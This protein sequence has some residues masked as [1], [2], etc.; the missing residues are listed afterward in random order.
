MS[1]QTT[2]APVRTATTVEA[3]IDHAFRVFTEGF[4]TWWPAS[5]HTGDDGFVEA[6]LEPREGGRWYERRRDGA[7]G[8]WGSVLAWEPPHRLLLAWQLDADFQY[9]PDPARATEVEVRFT[10]EGPDRTRVEL[11]HRLL[12][13]FGDRADAVRSAIGSDGGWPGILA[14]FA[15]AAG[16]QR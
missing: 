4:G 14:Q 8:E 11:E 6:V 15:A 1:E 7:D 5:H 10:A 13:R 2:I 3:P 16:A 9:D 12:E